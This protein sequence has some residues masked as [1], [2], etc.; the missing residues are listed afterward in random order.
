MKKSIERL[1]TVLIANR[2]RMRR[3]I[4]K[5]GMGAV[6]EAFD[7]NLDKNVAVKL[8]LTDTLKD[9]SLIEEAVR[10]RDEARAIA[11]VKSPYL[12]TIIDAGD[13]PEIG[14]YIVYE[15][16]E[17]SSLADLLKS[18]QF[19]EKEVIEKIAKPLLLGLAEL[20]R[21]GIVHR[22][23]K[24]D[25]IL[26]S[27]E[28][29][30][31]VG[32]L[33]LAHFEGREAKTKTG[34]VVGTPGY[35]AP[36]AFLED[37]NDAT[38]LADIYSAALVIIESIIG[39]SPFKGDNPTALV[40]EQI[41][42]RMTTMDLVELGVSENLA[43]LLARAIS[44]KKEERPKN[45]KD[46][47]E[48]LKKAQRRPRPPQP[49]AEQEESAAIHQRGP[50][51]GFIFLCLFGLILFLAVRPFYV[52]KKAQPVKEKPIDGQKE[53]RALL[54]KFKDSQAPSPKLLA[55]IYEEGQIFHQRLKKKGSKGQKVWKDTLHTLGKKA[56]PRLLLQSLAARSDRRDKILASAQAKEAVL[57][58]RSILKRTKKLKAEHVGLETFLFQHRFN[59]LASAG[60]KSLAK[61]IEPSR[62]FTNLLRNKIG[63]NSYQEAH[64]IVLLLCWATTYA[65]GRHLNSL[66]DMER[67]LAVLAHRPK[68]PEPV[69]GIIK[70]LTDQ[71]CEKLYKLDNPEFT[72]IAQAVKSKTPGMTF[73][74]ACEASADKAFRM[75]TT[76]AVTKGFLS[77][78]AKAKNSKD[79]LRTAK[80]ST[81]T[82]K[83]NQSLKLLRYAAWAYAGGTL[84]SN[85]EPKVREGYSDLLLDI[86][87]T[88]ADRELLYV[89]K[90]DWGL[91]FEVKETISRALLEVDALVYQLLE[92]KGQKQRLIYE[93]YLLNTVEEW[94]EETVDID[95]QQ[96]QQIAP[97]IARIKDEHSPLTHLLR[98]WYAFH[99]RNDEAKA[100]I[101]SKKAL[102]VG[103]QIFSAVK[104]P[105]QRTIDSNLVRLFNEVCKFRWRLLYH[106]KN[107]AKNLDRLKEA[108]WVAKFFAPLA[109]ERES[110]AGHYRV[111]WAQAIVHRTSAER[112]LGRGDYLEKN[113]KSLNIVI[114]RGRYGKVSG[115]A[116]ELLNKKAA[117]IPAP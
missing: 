112:T 94:I 97:V 105:S 42:R 72:A 21:Q 37:Y 91:G 28:G 80:R 2:F 33:G 11:K 3:I 5:G 31:K 77:D 52:P 36:E 75:S 87:E 53:L 46:F 61:I 48:D 57:E 59:C 62:R 44:I 35:L 74:S 66:K 69:E 24:P 64:R 116:Q 100:Y 107:R 41:A 38:E 96:A 93:T 19:S 45:A 106:T 51:L 14:P 63:E 40:K 34:I 47:Y 115:F 20:H 49:R 85:P 1:P 58:M 104:N 68:Y 6:Y 114:D 90:G 26:Q 54:L 39:R 43:P 13:E 83:L 65:K 55:R 110:P 81:D 82:K 27:D 89:K 10:L 70:R 108:K 60:S 15:L 17:K 56:P 71:L 79:L 67:G 32:D 86:A 23:I 84:I 101:D 8:I 111:A 109:K 30:F 7:E 78:A 12:V 50:M 88:R 16:L 9:E 18:N 102:D 99:V 76:V 29:L 113:K 22:D 25:N 92:I 98:A 73:A 4:G 103:K 117:G 95:K